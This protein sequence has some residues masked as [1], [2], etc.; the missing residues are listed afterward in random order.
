MPLLFRFR[1][2]CYIRQILTSRTAD[3]TEGRFGVHQPLQG[4]HCNLAPEEAFCQTAGRD[5][6]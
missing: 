1:V 5:R 4:Q 2:A 6:V 3:W